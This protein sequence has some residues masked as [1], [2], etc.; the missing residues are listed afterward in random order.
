MRGSNYDC[1][2]TRVPQRLVDEAFSIFCCGFDAD[3]CT[4]QEVD[5]FEVLI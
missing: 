2:W 5:A 4:E 1:N 3:A